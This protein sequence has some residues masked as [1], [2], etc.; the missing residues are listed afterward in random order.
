MYSQQIQA[1]HQ[2]L[3]LRLRLHQNM[4]SCNTCHKTCMSIPLLH[5]PVMRVQWEG[6]SSHLMQILVWSAV[7]DLHVRSTCSYWQ[8]S[9]TRMQDVVYD[10]PEIW[11]SFVKWRGLDGTDVDLKPQ[12]TFSL[13]GI[14]PDV[15]LPCSIFHDMLNPL[16]FNIW[17]VV[18]VLRSK[19]YVHEMCKTLHC[20][21]IYIYTAWRSGDWWSDQLWLRIRC[22]FNMETIWLF[23][24]LPSSAHLKRGFSSSLRVR[25]ADVYNN[26]SAPLKWMETGKSPPPPLSLLS[27]V[28][29][30]GYII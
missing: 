3:K 11:M 26:M 20:V 23:Y 6:C 5:Q 1:T 21:F 19:I 14:F 10:L 18:Y 29:P 13:N 22:F 28:F 12:C 25:H 24:M 30:S 7:L 16:C 9:V 27:L 8:D 17:F 2:I 4:I 15:L